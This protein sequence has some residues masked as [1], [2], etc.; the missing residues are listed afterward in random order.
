MTKKLIAVWTFATLACVLV[1]ALL[2]PTMPVASLI[3][4]A[5]MV[6]DA[7]IAGVEYKWT[8]R[9]RRWCLQRKLE[10]LDSQIRESVEALYDM[11]FRAG[12]ILERW[13]DDRVVDR[14]KLAQRIDD[15]TYVIN[16]D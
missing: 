3:I 6:A 5:L 1:A 2:W 13:I 15:L 12:E 4:V 9:A 8:L 16:H 10:F 7:W 11:D 14:R